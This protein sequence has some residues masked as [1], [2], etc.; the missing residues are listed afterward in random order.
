MDMPSL[1]SVNSYHYIRGGSDALYFHHADL[2]EKQG[3]KNTFFSME[4]PK[5]VGCETSQYFADRIDF[6]VA[7]SL[8]EKLSQSARIIY[9]KQAQSRLSELLNKRNID[10]AHYHCIY[11]H[12]S[13]SV[14]VEAKRRGIPTVMTAHDLKIACPAYKMMNDHGVCEKCRGG[15]VWN[16]ALDRCIKGS[17]AAS[18]LIMIESAV[19]KAFRLYDRYLDRIVTPSRF[20]RD[21]LIEWGWSPEKIVH[22]PN[23]IEFVPKNIASAGRYILYFGRLA[24]EKGLSTLISAAAEAGVPVKIAGTGPEEARLKALAQRLFAP[25]EFLGFRSGDDLWSLVDGARA[26]ALPSEWYENGPMSVIEAFARGKPL[27]GARIGGIPELIE[28]GATGWSFTSGD[29][30]DLA[31]KLSTAASASD[32]ELRNMATATRQMVETHFSKTR[33]FDEI[34][35]LYSDIGVQCNR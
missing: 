25:V 13:P 30:L 17:R 19:H 4:H 1:L 22:I 34:T 31:D 3:W 12:L 15:K 6:E 23:F 26:I 2:F 35:Q 7:T 20:Y 9:S 33:Y 11:H 14:I 16:V 28:E 29:R 21:K 27:I 32:G 8:K 5:N 10:V 18:A 24:P